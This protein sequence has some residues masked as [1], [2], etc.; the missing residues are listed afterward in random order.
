MNEELDSQ[1]SAMFDDELPPA[2]CELLARRLSRDEQL[3]S[4]WG[5]YALIGAAI[6]AER[7]AMLQPRIAGRVSQALRAEPVLTER[8]DPRRRVAA[9]SASWWQP[10]A[11]AAVAAGVA[12][13]AILWMRSEGTPEAT[14]PLPRTVLAPVPAPAPVPESPP[15]SYTVPHPGPVNGTSLAN[16]WVAHYEWSSP[17]A[18][19]AMMFGLLG[20]QGTAG[21]QTGSQE[22]VPGDGV[23]QNDPKTV[24]Q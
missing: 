7:G 8:S 17:V 19:Q 4:R 23:R 16:Y 6:R 20:G 15:D 3:K 13:A 2:E 12:T 24:E 10:L 5:R 9:G 18:R 11:S 1:L 21:T 22:S 14:A